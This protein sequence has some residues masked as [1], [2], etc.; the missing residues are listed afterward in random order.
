LARASPCHGEGRGFESL[1]PLHYLKFFQLSHPILYIVATPIGNLSDVSMRAQNILSSVSFILCEDTRHTLKLLTHFG[2]RNHLESLHIHNEKNKV[3]YL[4]DKLIHSETQSAALVSDAGTPAICDPGS[5]LVAAAHE[6]NVK[7]VSVPGPC[8]MAS[9]LAASGFIQP[10]TL[11][12]GFLSKNKR[13]QFEEFQMWVCVS[14][15][16]AV[17]FDSPKRILD[18]LK[19][20]NEFFTNQ[21]SL[22]DPIFKSIEVCVSREISKKFEEHKRFFLC[23]AIE[24]FKAQLQILGEF[25][26][27]LNLNKITRPK[28]E[29]TIEFAANE[30]ALMSKTKSIPLKTCCK[31]VAAKYDFNA[32]EVYSIAS[33]L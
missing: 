23:D 3:D 11:F 9:S 10:R 21:I 2:I 20:L 12:S 27:C 6:K 33:K 17:F 16:I 15:C 5:Y 7:I 1:F 24:F 13:E 28:D 18:T 32:K 29:V 22:E 14:P 4:I 26:I 31:E 19:N 30:A 8:S 25:V